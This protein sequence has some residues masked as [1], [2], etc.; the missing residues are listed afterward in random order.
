MALG[1]YAHPGQIGEARLDSLLTQYNTLL[2][3][4]Q[5][6]NILESINSALFPMGGR[7]NYQSDSSTG[8]TVAL[9]SHTPILFESGTTGSNT[10]DFQSNG[11]SALIVLQ[12]SNSMNFNDAGGGPGDTIIGSSGANQYIKVNSGDN[13][14]VSG[15][16]K[17][18]LVAGAGNDSLYAGHKSHDLM[19]AR[20]GSTFMRGGFSA[21]STDTLVGGSGSDTIKVKFGN[22]V[23]NAGSGAETIISF[24]NGSGSSTGPNGD[25]IS[26]TGNGT[27]LVNIKAGT[28]MDTVV[29]GG[30]MGNDTIQTAGAVT[31]DIASS[32]KLTGIDE[33]NGVTTLSFADNQTLTYSGAGHVT[34][35][36][37]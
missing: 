11:V 19:E 22:N 16:G 33:T 34:L 8:G 26:L 20:N 29:F 12:A 14:I 23:I 35:N 17:S 36:F 31:V 6:V 15:N 37:S 24:D 28:A 25:S 10:I 5:G 32:E 27:D 1:P 18:T 13:V 3:L 4:P 30:T 2:N 7:V 9:N 21:S